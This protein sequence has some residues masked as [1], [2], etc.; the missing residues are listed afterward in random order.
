MLT[1]LQSSAAFVLVIFFTNA[2][3]KV[4]VMFLLFRLLAFLC[5]REYCVIFVTK[6]LTSLMLFEDVTCNTSILLMI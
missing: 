5:C 4:L 3:F 2:T 1:V 6:R